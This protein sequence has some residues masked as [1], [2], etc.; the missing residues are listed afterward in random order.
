M[1]IVDPPDGE[2]GVTAAT[3]QR[4]AAD[5]ITD[6]NLQIGDLRHTRPGHLR[7]S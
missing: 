2:P 1:P 3:F 6:V 4:P 5:T 7:S